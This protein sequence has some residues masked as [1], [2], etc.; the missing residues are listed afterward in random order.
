MDQRIEWEN[1]G[2]STCSMNPSVCKITRRKGEHNFEIA[3]H[4]FFYRSLDKDSEMPRLG[5]AK[6]T[7]VY[8]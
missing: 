4:R 7:T 2:S 1:T 3:S 8:L 6:C 5:V